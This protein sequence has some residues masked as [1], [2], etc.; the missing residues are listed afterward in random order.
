MTIY[1]Q[2]PNY[3]SESEEENE[4][5]ANA[6]APKRR[7]KSSRIW[8]LEKAFINKKE[9][10][11]FIESEKTWGNHY[12]DDTEDGHKIYFR[13]N[14]AKLRGNQCPAGVYLFFDWH[15]ENKV[16][17][18]R[19]EEEHDHSY[20]VTSIYGLCVEAIGEIEKLFDLKLKP[21][22]ILENLREKNWI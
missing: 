12:A 19:T 14:K 5:T 16:E 6:V 13:C 2:V 8:R 4:T 20:L 11:E 9:A 21:K 7:L 17:L 1:S 18:F 15:E 10:L 22:V 3:I